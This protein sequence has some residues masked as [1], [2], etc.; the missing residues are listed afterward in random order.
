MVDCPDINPN[1]L[2]LITI[3]IHVGNYVVPYH[4]FLKFAQDTRQAHRPIVTSKL[5]V[6]FLENWRDINSFPYRWKLSLLHCGWEYSI[7]R[8]GYGGSNF[9][10]DPWVYLVGSRWFGRL[11]SKE[12]LFY[13]FFSEYHIFITFQQ[14][15]ARVGGGV[16]PCVAKGRL[17]L[18]SLHRVCF[19]LNCSPL[20]L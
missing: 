15:D 16:L 11:Q 20:W 19:S 12:F 8:L 9:F 3:G 7:Q 18:H 5:S 14:W 2:L 1:C 17:I 4:R 13:L 6:P 10:R